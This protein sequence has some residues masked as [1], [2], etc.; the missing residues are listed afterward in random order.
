MVTITIALWKSA[1]RIPFPKSGG[2]ADLDPLPLGMQTENA[3]KN[4][5]FANIDTI[6]TY[7]LRA[8]PLCQGDPPWLWSLGITSHTMFPL[9]SCSHRSLHINESDFL[10]FWCQ[11]FPGVT[12]VSSSYVLWF[13]CLWTIRY[14][15][16]LLVGKFTDFRESFIL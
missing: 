15:L 12:Y 6:Y 5:P 2:C 1:K 10:L 7:H 16:V 13:W 9:L 8:L 3:C 4:G 11:Y 14:L